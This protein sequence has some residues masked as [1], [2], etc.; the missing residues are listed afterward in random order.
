MDL[1]GER[2]PLSGLLGAVIVWSTTDPFRQ[3]LGHFSGSFLTSSFLFHVLFAR[4]SNR[5]PI[6]RHREIRDCP[7]TSFYYWS[8][9]D[10]L[11]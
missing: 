5:T 11:L 6:T 10:V 2:F 7:D 4:Y 1:G 3:F 8:P 9:D